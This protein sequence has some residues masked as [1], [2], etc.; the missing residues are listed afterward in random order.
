MHCVQNFLKIVSKIK[1][2]LTIT[3]ISILSVFEMCMY[4][5]TLLLL[6]FNSLIYLFP[7]NLGP[8]ASAGILHMQ[9]KENTTGL[10]LRCWH[11]LQLGMPPEG[12]HINRTLS[13]LWIAVFCAEK[14]VSAPYKGLDSSSSSHGG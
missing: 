14:I 11:L 6:G 8:L 10:C 7:A 12:A 9:T 1:H 2:Y 13:N 4:I 3:C 5:Q